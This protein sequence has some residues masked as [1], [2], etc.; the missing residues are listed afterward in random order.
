MEIEVKENKSGTPVSTDNSVVIE[1]AVKGL[2]V[3]RDKI[4]IPYRQFPQNEV[5]NKIVITFIQEIMEDV[6]VIGETLT[7]IKMLMYYVGR[8]VR[9][10][11]ARLDTPENRDNATLIMHKE[12]L[13]GLAIDGTELRYAAL[14]KLKVLQQL[15]DGMKVLKSAVMGGW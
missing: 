9:A 2:R 12:S 5:D 6:R 4:L 7:D 3:A 10:T 14:D 8:Q 15:Y 11:T 1:A 13:K